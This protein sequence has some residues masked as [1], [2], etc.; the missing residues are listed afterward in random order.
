MQ[1]S[2]SAA[3][4]ERD[5][6]LQHHAPLRLQS[7]NPRERSSLFATRQLIEM[8]YLRAVRTQNTRDYI[9]ERVTNYQ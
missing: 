4:S 8:I 1:Y 7:C 3:M 6:I 9:R 2:I 5:I